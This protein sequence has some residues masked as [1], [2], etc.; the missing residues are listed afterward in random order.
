[1]GGKRKIDNPVQRAA[2]QLRKT[3]AVQDEY[4]R[5]E[6]ERREREARENAERV[7]RHR[8]HNG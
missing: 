4:H 3:K 5:Q 8:R 1:M 2:A 6:R 7:N